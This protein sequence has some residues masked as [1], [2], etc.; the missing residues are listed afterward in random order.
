MLLQAWEMHHLDTYKGLHD[1]DQ[2]LKVSSLSLVNSVIALL[3]F[4]E[5]AGICWCVQWNDFYLSKWVGIR[6]AALLIL[7]ERVCHLKTRNQLWNWFWLLGYQ[8]GEDPPRQSGGTRKFCDSSCFVLWNQTWFVECGI[9]T[10][11][12]FEFW[13]EVMLA[14][15]T[16]RSL[17]APYII[18][19]FRVEPLSFV[20]EGRHVPS[21]GR[22]FP[23]NR[24]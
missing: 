11:L 22:R 9:N 2:L 21:I 19:C 24:G 14:R 20:P 7:S 12:I 23:R 17:K 15:T 1:P 4:I 13:C 8:S 18:C 16:S 3:V 5:S 10:S 6:I